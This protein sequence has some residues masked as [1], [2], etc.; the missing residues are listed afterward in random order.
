MTRIRH[1]GGANSKG[2]RGSSKANLENLREKL[3]EKDINCKEKID[4]I[5]REY[6]VPNYV[7]VSDD[8]QKEVIELNRLIKIAEKGIIN[9]EARKG[10]L[11]K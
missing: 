7:D 4:R 9:F 5:Y 11:F 6:N 10:F 2:S 3:K 8:C 1:K